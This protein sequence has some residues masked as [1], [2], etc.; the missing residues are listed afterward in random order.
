MADA[1]GGNDRAAGGNPLIGS[2]LAL[3]FPNRES[4]GKSGVGL[5]LHAVLFPGAGAQCDGGKSKESNSD[6]R[7]QN[8]QRDGYDQGKAMGL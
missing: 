8:H 1:G 2:E 5:G 7:E 4:E 3:E 6:D